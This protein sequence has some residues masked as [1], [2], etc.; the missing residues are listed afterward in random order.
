VGK[1]PAQLTCDLDQAHVLIQSKINPCRWPGLNP[2]PHAH[3][4]K[5]PE[6]YVEVKRNKFLFPFV[7][8]ASGLL[9][10]QLCLL[11]ISLSW[12][13]AKEKLKIGFA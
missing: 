6:L 1:A 11:G 12:Q 5:H 10:D 2:T 9:K 8:L 4:C 3:F 13:L 7:S